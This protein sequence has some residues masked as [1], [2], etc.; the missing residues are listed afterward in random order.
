MVT[1]GLKDA[2]CAVHA[3]QLLLPN[4]QRIGGICGEANGGG[5]EIISSGFRSL[6]AVLPS[7][8]VRRGSLIEWLTAGES[9]DASGATGAI[10]LAFIIACQLAVPRPCCGR[11]RSGRSQSATSNAGTIIVID[12]QGR[13]YPP[14]VMP[15]LAGRQLV[16]ARPACEADEMWAIDQSLRCSGV[17]AVLAWPKRIHP[18]AMR[19]WQ[20][21]ARVSQAVGLFVRPENTRREPSWAEARV[22][23]SAI[24]GEAL[25]MR[26]LRLALT[27]GPW[28]GGTIV[29]DRSIEIVLDLVRGCEG[30][31][32]TIKT[33][34]AQ[35][36]A[37]T[38]LA[39]TTAVGLTQSVQTD[40]PRAA[41]ASRGSHLLHNQGGLSCR[42]S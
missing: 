15:W 8:G 2:G 26:R 10:A 34:C 13:F 14:A 17:A 16:V 1:F 30:S 35:I 38:T 12:R 3:G 27:S 41:G 5:R 33:G 21:S 32:A 28:M 18:T 22:A 23:V 6:D 36:T 42:A 9:C 4:G 25:A 29:E 11:A 39:A 20:L 24:A 40:A 31:S 37:A 19:R 7:A